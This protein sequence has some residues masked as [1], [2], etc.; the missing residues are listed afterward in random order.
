MKVHLINIQEVI[1]LPKK[2][3]FNNRDF[4]EYPLWT[5]LHFEHGFRDFVLP[6]FDPLT[7]KLSTENVMVGDI[8][9]KLVIDLS[10]EE[11]DANL[12]PFY[13]NWLK[14]KVTEL[15]IKAEG[16]AIG[17]TGDIDYIKNQIELYK[18]KYRNCITL[19][20]I[21]EVDADLA[22]EGMR[23]FGVELE[24]F[25][26]VVIYLYEDSSAVFDLFVHYIEQCRSAILTLIQNKDWTKCE[27]AK[28]I[29]DGLQSPA[30][31]Q[32]VKNLI[33]AL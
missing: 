29:V 23:D 24:V 4:E 28:T 14:Q 10:V 9:T 27:Q 8:C 21:A 12:T 16:A 20:P 7:Q 2:F 5:E 32:N 15:M 25:K 3:S 19:T 30:E 18:N 1:D 26:Q 17:K 31:S 33:M 11:I 6:T 13:S 22:L